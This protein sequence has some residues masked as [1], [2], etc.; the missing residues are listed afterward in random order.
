MSRIRTVKPEF[1]KHEELS[2]LPEATH[3]LAAALLNYADDEG[4]FN[5]NAR[6]I[7][8][9]LFPLREPSVSI[10]DSLIALAGIGYIRLGNGADGK[11]YG[12]IV[13]FAEHQRVN[14][15]TPSRIKKIGVEFDDVM[16]AH[17]QLTEP[18]VIAHH[19]NGKERKGREQGKELRGM[20][21][22]EDGQPQPRKA[23]RPPAKTQPTSDG[24]NTWA[25]YASAYLDRYGT[26]PVRNARVNAQLAQMAKRVPADEAPHVARWYVASNSALYVR[27]KHCVDLLLRDC[28]GLRTEWATRRRVTDTEARQA[29][30]HQATVDAARWVGENMDQLRQARKEGKI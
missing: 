6:L 18:S 12:W 26:E 20:S 5:A 15:P 27:S 11:R 4:F 10:H 25:A 17:A 24:S 7:A 14:R 23:D 16:T 30:Q 1:W 2:S 19:L 3:M 8:A 29:D 28:E 9:E 22:H 13:K 21:P